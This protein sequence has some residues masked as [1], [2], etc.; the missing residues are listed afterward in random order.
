MTEVALQDRRIL[1]VEDDYLIAMDIRRDLE[2]AGAVVIGPAPSVSQALRLL[3]NEAR[4]D[5]A[6]LDVNLG[7]ERSFPIA[8]ALQ[9]SAV[10]FLFA[11]GYNSADI[12]DEW[13]RAEVVLKPLNI[14]A[15]RKL[16]ASARAA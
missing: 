14:G 9:A 16:L 5:A 4:I 10:P 3:E 11:T 13:R 12:P 15:V 7:G 1:V 8:E 2:E 6:V